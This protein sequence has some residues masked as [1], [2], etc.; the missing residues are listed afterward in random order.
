MKIQG[1]QVKQVQQKPGTYKG[2][3]AEDEIV[4]EIKIMQ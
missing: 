1:R 3:V 2:T 4:R